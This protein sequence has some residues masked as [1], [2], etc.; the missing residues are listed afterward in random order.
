MLSKLDRVI[1]KL[2]RVERVH[3]AKRI[4]T[5]FPGR[6]WLRASVKHV[7]HQTEMTGSVDCKSDSGLRC[8]A[9]SGTNIQLVKELALS[10][11]DA[12]L[13]GATAW[14]CQRKQR[15]L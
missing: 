6:N 3:G 14:V 15:T 4:M 5:E 8:S 11:E 10:Q 12:P 7:L 1:I 13:A 2:L 9:C